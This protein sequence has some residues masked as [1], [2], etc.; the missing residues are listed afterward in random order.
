MV[1]W[2]MGAGAHGEMASLLHRVDHTSGIVIPFFVGGLLF[3]AGYLALGMGLYR[4]RATA[5]WFAA[6]VMIGGVVFDVS[7]LTTSLPL[8]IVAAAFIVVG[9]GSIGRRV[10]SEPDDAWE[11]TPEKEGFRPLL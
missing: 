7:M 1:T 2:Q 9:Q 6:C 5:S 8:A 4:A 3:G 11:H 10:W